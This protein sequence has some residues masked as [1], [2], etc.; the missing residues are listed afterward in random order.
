MLSFE[1]FN[2]NGITE[3]ETANVNFMCMFN[4]S[5]IWDITMQITRSIQ[6][7]LMKH[8]IQYKMGLLAFKARHS[9]SPPYLQD[10]L[11]NYHQSR[12][13]VSSSAH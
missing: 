9:P 13:L 5:Q 3:L 6:I 7:L 11:L 8:G 12:Q 2:L 10:I 4:C 1:F